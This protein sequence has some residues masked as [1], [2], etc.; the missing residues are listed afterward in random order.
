MPIRHLVA[1][2]RLTLARL[3]PHL[4]F[5]STGSRP[6]SQRLVACA[7]AESDIGKGKVWLVGAGPG[8]PDLLTVRAAR[9]L[10]AAEVV[11]YDDLISE[12]AAGL[13]HPDA[14]LIYVGKRGG[15]NST[16][17]QDIDSLLV[18]LC[19]EG[20]QV[21]RLKGGCCSVFSRVRSELRALKAAGCD[22]AMVPGI[23]SALAGPLFAGIS[24]TDKELSRHFLV[25]SCHDPGILDW[26]AF[27]GID[28][29][30]LLMAARQ[31]AVVVSKLCNESDRTPDTP[32][33]IIRS[34]GTRQEA[35]FEGTLSN[36]ISVTEGELLSPCVVVVG[37]VAGDRT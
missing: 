14:E 4:R 3:G 26:T 22:V 18:R 20:R 25:T 13:A 24:L 16:P 15:M 2:T 1:N 12:V 6:D 9:L 36:I 21:V 10:E 7:K 30:V 37:K 28:T 11:V 32:V 8:P 27:S 29:L 33:L 17:Q 19:T 34:A 35:I 23:S 5:S 31:L